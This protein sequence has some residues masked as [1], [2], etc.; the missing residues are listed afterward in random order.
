M[1]KIFL[2][3]LIMLALANSDQFFSGYSY[4]NTYT[5]KNMKIGQAQISMQARGYRK[6][7]AY[8]DVAL[9]SATG[10]IGGNFGLTEHIEL[11]MNMVLYQD[12]HKDANAETGVQGLEQSVYNSPDAIYLRMKFGN[13]QFNLFDEMIGVAG[14]ASTYRFISKPTGLMLEPYS[15]R[16]MQFSLTGLFSLYLEPLYF[17]NGQQLHFNLGF[18]N[19]NDSPNNQ[20]Y[21]AFTEST[22]EMTYGLSYVYPYGNINYFLEV[23]GNTFIQW[24]EHSGEI[25]YSTEPFL[26]VTP[27]IKWKAF[28]WLE[29]D[30]GLD[31]L[32][33]TKY[34]SQKD[35]PKF[36]FVNTSNDLP[37]YPAW[38]FLLRT[39]FYPTT[40]FSESEGFKGGEQKS[41][42]GRISD[43][44]ELFEW[45]IEE[46][47]RIELIDMKLEKLKKERKE[48][49]KKVDK[50]KEEIE[51]DK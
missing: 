29:F 51:K 27:G 18:I 49:E 26:Y 48:L 35:S 30:F 42:D 4:F 10:I 6:D 7:K 8:G 16:N 45:L 1:K 39:N 28:P 33:Y 41:Q 19:H 50:L 15:T 47:D 37:Y 9:T 21:T 44:K 3:I 17:E 43:R 11:G 24:Y 2:A 34:D 32:A 14:V 46:P 13:Y 12:I 25:P 38:R 5:A 22:M 36:E 40:A 23:Y 31:I 20:S